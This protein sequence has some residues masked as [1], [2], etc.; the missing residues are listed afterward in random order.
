MEFYTIFESFNVFIVIEINLRSPELATTTKYYARLQNALSNEALSKF[1][2]RFIW[3]PPYEKDESKRICTSSVAKYFT[4]LGYNVNLNQTDY[5]S[6]IAYSLNMPKLGP[7]S[8]DLV[9]INDQSKFLATPN[10]LA[11]YAGLLALSCNMEPTEYLNT[12]S[13]SGHTVEVGNALIIQLKGM[14]SC[15]LVKMLFKKLR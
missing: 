14:F 11:E 4:D 10:E 15:N 7:E 9:E 3:D 12:W 6:K 1:A 13:F 5:K 2:V 8:D